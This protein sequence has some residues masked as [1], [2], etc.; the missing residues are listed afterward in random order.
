[1]S[2]HNTEGMAMEPTED[3]TLQQGMFPD[4]SA[5]GGKPNAGSGAPATEDPRVSRIILRN[6]SS[7][8]AQ[9][10][11]EKSTRM[12]EQRAMRHAERN[13]PLLTPT[14]LGAGAKPRFGNAGVKLSL[15]I[16]VVAGDKVVS[17]LTIHSYFKWQQ[18]KMSLFCR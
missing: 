1:M 10:G 5:A 11:A 2:L 7:R 6:S 13:P 12:K 4:G 9:A 15:G 3:P 8:R 16:G 14:A 18:I 17:F